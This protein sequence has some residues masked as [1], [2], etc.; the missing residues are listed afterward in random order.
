MLSLIDKLT[1]TGEYLSSSIV[2]STYNVYRNNCPDN[3][4]C[5]YIFT[6]PTN[7]D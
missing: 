4:S 5:C 6:M 1:W 2:L 7:Y 3:I